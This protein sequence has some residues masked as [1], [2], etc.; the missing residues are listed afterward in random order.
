MHKIIF[1][2]LFFAHSTTRFS[3]SSLT[4]VWVGYSGSCIVLGSIYWRPPPRITWI[5]RHEKTFY[6]SSLWIL[7]PP[8]LQYVTTVPLIFSL[9]FT[10][11]VFKRSTFKR[12]PLK[13]STW[14]AN[15]QRIFYNGSSLSARLQRTRLQFG[16]EN[17]YPNLHLSLC[18]E[19]IGKQCHGSHF[20]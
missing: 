8:L 7:A 4:P 10:L 14:G 17:I 19:P 1:T 5:W 11:Q 16:L 2:V 9:W 15:C 6:V 12:P 20:G 18:C 3:P 13:A